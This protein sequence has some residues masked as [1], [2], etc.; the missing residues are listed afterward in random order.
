[1][2]QK[3]IV[4]S[5]T[6]VLLASAMF[7]IFPLKVHATD[8]EISGFSSYRFGMTENEIRKLIKFDRQEIK[9]N[10]RGNIINNDKV[11]LTGD[12]PIEIAGSKYNLVLLLE[13]GR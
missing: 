12:K 6:S 7:A 10:I 13:E 4:S 3:N 2:A 8:K 5:L 9:S 11:Q 1:M